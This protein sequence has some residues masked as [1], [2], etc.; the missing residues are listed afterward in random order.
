MQRKMSQLIRTYLMLISIVALCLLPTS[1]RAQQLFPN[2]VG[3]KC[4]YKAMIEMPK[5]YI[6]GVCVMCNDSTHITAS[7]FNEF[8]LS[9]LDFSYDFKRD[10]VTLHHVMKLLN[11]WY[12]KRVLKKDLRNLIH[13]LQGGSGEYRNDKY[14][15]IYTLSPIS[16]DIIDNQDEI[17]E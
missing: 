8:G 2:K 5:A 11:R 4:R 6:S 12:I 9:A 3:E 14:K 17:D 1:L 10:K 16:N 15:L 7:I 13:N